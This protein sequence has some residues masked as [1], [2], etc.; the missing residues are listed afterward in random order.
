VESPRFVELLDGDL[1]LRPPRLE[2]ADL[3][4]RWWADEEVLFGFATEPRSA[5]E[6]RAAFPEMEAEAR[7]IGHWI[8][9]VMELAG[10]AVGSIWLSHWDLDAATC[11]LNILIG[12]PELRSRGLARR[13]IRLLCRWAFREMDLRRIYLC[14]REDHLPAQ[15]SYTGAGARTGEVRE[16]VVPWRGEIVCFREMYLDRED[17]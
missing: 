17:F 12:E 15:R 6:I 13:A 5:E 14:P 7:D 1:R 10:R 4:A 9:F 2:E 11:E 8:E 3:Y 16:Q